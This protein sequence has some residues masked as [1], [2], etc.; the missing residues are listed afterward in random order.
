MVMQTT[1][2]MEAIS[3]PGSGLAPP[4]SR[5]FRIM[6]TSIQVQLKKVF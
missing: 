3:E 6:S 1:C 5:Y 4:F 2:V